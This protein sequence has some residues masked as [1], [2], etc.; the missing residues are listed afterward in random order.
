MG[1]WK[2]LGLCGATVIGIIMAVIV[3][4]IAQALSNR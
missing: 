1:F 2:M 4:P 3:Y